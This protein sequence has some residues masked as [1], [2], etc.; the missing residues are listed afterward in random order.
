MLQITQDNP[1]AML[2]ESDP[3]SAL[4]ASETQG[5]FYETQYMILNSRPMAY[6]I[7]DTLNLTERPEFKKLQEKMEDKPIVKLRAYMPMCYWMIWKLNL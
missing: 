1:A 5:R 3:I 7:M 6:K 4:I 2:G